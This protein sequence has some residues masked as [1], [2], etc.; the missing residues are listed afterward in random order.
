M[1]TKTLETAIQ[2]FALFG[3]PSREDIKICRAEIEPAVLR[4]VDRGMSANAIVETLAKATMLA[5]RRHDVR[6]VF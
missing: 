3:T 4:L 2:E 5:L 1:T 6:T